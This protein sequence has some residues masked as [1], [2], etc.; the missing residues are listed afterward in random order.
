MRERRP[1]LATRPPT[2]PAEPARAREFRLRGVV[3]RLEA[4]NQELRL[5]LAE[6]VAWYDAFDNPDPTKTV[7]LGEGDFE[8]YRKLA[9]AMPARRAP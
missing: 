1:R 8:R 6:L 9:K 5:A 3:D 7:W 4:T 2:R